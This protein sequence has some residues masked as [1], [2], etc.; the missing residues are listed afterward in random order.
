M[1]Q[2]GQVME[3]HLYDGDVL[4]DVSLFTILSRII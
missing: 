4:A 1:D 2:A 3:R